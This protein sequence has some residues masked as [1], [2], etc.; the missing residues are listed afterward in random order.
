[1]SGFENIGQ[2]FHKKL[3]FSVNFKCCLGSVNIYHLMI[4]KENNNNCYSLYF[5][6]NSLLQIHNHAKSNLYYNKISIFPP[7]KK[8]FLH[9]KIVRER[10]F[11][12]YF[13][14]IVCEQDWSTDFEKYLELF[15]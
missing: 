3:N 9:K 14:S 10:D 15:H 7:K 5:R 2:K 1:M 13:N 12:I 4:N 11:Q 6:Y 8:C